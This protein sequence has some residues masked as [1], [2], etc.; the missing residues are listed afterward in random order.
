[1][2]VVTR[3]NPRGFT[4]VELLVVIAIIGILIA[5]LL[6]AVQAAR[7]AARRINCTN[8]VKQIGLAL[9]NYHSSN[10]IFPPGGWTNRGAIG[11]NGV[12][13]YVILLPYLEKDMIQ[14]NFDFSKELDTYISSTGLEYKP[15]PDL[16]CPSFHLKYYEAAGTKWYIQHYN[17]IMGAAGQ[18]LYN[19]NGSYHQTRG[20]SGAGEFG[21]TGVLEIDK[22]HRI[23]DISD[24][25]SNT[26]MVGELAWDNGTATR[27]VLPTHWVR[28]TTGGSDSA[29]AYCCRNLK[30]PINS[31]PMIDGDW[32][33]CSFGSVHPGGCNFLAADGAV[34]FVDENSE[35]KILQALVTRAGSEIAELD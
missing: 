27:P 26:F 15:V 31:V 18:D 14:E 24:G 29:Y 19:G 20:P 1:M 4:L 35:L 8:N 30:Y 33:N 11:K 28:S 3:T 34:R 25:T 12:S 9:H 6:P 17:P 23:R 16:L 5:L 13:M 7:E 21:T 10:N 32:N 22:Q 2:Q